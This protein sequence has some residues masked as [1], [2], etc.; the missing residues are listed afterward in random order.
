MTSEILGFVCEWYDPQPM[1]TRKF[2]T[3]VFVDDK[4]VEVS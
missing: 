1:K 2:L 3:K 4:Q